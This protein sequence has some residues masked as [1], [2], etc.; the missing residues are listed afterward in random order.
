LLQNTAIA[1]KSIIWHRHENVV[2][3]K[4]SL[5]TEDDDDDGYGEPQVGA[6][7]E[8]MKVKRTCSFREFLCGYVDDGKQIKGYHEVALDFFKH[9]SVHKL[10]TPSPNYKQYRQTAH[11]QAEQF[12]ACIDGLGEHQIAVLIDFSMNYSHL[13]LEETSGEHWCHHQTTIVPVVVYRR[14]GSEVQAH[15]RVFMSN[16]LIHSN[17][18]VQHIMN[19]VLSTEKEADPQLSH[20]HMWSDGC[21]SQLKS[22]WQIWWLTQINCKDWGGGRCRVHITGNY[23][24]SCHGKG[25]CSI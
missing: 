1:E 9:R 2:T 22:R 6:K 18:M 12:D 17:Q 21:G 25:G 5:P 20:I 10:Y 15:S 13:H 4:A 11:W 8:S 14:V 3:G 23:F 7:S 16:D 19:T 24:Q